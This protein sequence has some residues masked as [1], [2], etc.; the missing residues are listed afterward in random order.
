MATLRERMAVQGFDRRNVRLPTAAQ[1]DDP[2]EMLRDVA[3]ETAARLEAGAR[4]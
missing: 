3:R 4:L 2:S 1:L